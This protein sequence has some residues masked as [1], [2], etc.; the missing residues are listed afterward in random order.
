M[1][2]NRLQTVEN[3]RRNESI[4]LK[5]GKLKSSEANQCCGFKIIAFVSGCDFSGN[6]GSGTDVTYLFL[7]KEAKANF[8]FKEEIFKVYSDIFVLVEVQ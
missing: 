6:F 1:P 3:L 7:S 5:C 8:N 4:K 2:L